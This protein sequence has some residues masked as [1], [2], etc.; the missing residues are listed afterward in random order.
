MKTFIQQEI[1]L[2]TGTTLSKRQLC[3]KN[4]TDST[5]HLLFTEQLEEACWNGMLY[6][7]LPEVIKKSSSGNRLSLWQIR[8]G[9]SFLEI[10]LSE[11]PASFED[12]YSLNPYYSIWSTSSN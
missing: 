12:Q 10:D 9:A 5:N 6:E 2:I 7:L 4:E 3:A 8:H 11:C 1:L